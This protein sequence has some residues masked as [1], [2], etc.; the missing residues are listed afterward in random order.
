[1]PVPLQKVNPVAPVP[2]FNLATGKLPIDTIGVE[3]LLATDIGDVPVSLVTV[4]PPEAETAAHSGKVP[5]EFI[6][7]TKPAEPEE[8]GNEV[9]IVGADA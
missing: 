9:N 1:M 4:Q 5:A 8:T 3:V 7:S 6:L 2:L